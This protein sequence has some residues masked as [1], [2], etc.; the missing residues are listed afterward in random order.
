MI[1]FIFGMTC[2]IRTDLSEPGFR[3]NS[4][5]GLRF[6]ARFVGRFV[7]CKICHLKKVPPQI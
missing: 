5:N 6:A 1:F 4:P 7:L 2:I 3:I